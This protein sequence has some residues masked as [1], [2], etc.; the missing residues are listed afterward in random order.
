MIA[1]SDYV[2]H[3]AQ[4]ACRLHG[5]QTHVSVRTVATASIDAVERIASISEENNAATEEVA[6]ASEELSAQVSAAAGELGVM[7]DEL[8][9]QV[10]VFRVD[11]SGSTSLRTVGG[12]DAEEGEAA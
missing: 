5:S 12:S 9:A 11:G 8:R 10:S 2:S 6:A 7:A 4:S 1:A 3:R